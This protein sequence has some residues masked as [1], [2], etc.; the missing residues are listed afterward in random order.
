MSRIR[1]NPA[2]VDPELLAILV[3][4][5]SRQPLS[6]AGPALV[7]RLNGEIAAGR[8]RNA[9]GEAVKERLDGGLVRADGKVLYPV[10]DDIPVLL[11][12][13]GIAL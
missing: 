7:A 13:E 9:G 10:R 11:V 12:E 3:C 4:P 8:L 2:G 5:E 1:K 6:E